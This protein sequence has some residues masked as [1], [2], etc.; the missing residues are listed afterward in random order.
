LNLTKAGKNYS[1]TGSNIQ[2]NL[3]R[4][5]SDTKTNIPSS[6][7]P[8][9]TKTKTKAKAKA[10]A[11]TTRTNSEAEIKKPSIARKKRKKQK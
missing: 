4:A 9:K 10:K 1:K 11:K 5:K 8:P 7:L 6:E 3:F 2:S